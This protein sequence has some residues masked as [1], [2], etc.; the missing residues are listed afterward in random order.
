ME[1]IFSI[2]QNLTF[3]KREAPN[4][5]DK[6]HEVRELIEE[7]NKHM[8]EVCVRDLMCCLGDTKDVAQRITIDARKPG[9]PTDLLKQSFRD[10]PCCSH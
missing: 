8:F 6:F 9:A 7:W 3:T 4:F 10:A 2:T 5:V 1:P